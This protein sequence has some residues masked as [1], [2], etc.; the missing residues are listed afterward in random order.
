MADHPR[1]FISYSWTTP[2]HEK[3]V[4]GL[5]EELVSQGVDVIF[6]KWHL[7]PGHDANVF[8]ESMVTDPSVN[9]VILVCD[10]KY[11]QKSDERTG[12]AGTEAQIITPQL[13]AKS[14]QDKFVAVVREKH[15]N[16]AP[17][18]PVYYR[19][20]IFFDLSDDAKYAQEFEGLVR[21]AWDKPAY[22]KPELGKK[23]AFL[24]DDA[25]A[26]KIP[27]SVPFRRA[28]DAIR[29]GREYA[30][31]A[32]LEYFNVIVLEMD[33]FR[34]ETGSQN[35]DLFDEKILKNISEFIPYR[36]EFVEIIISIAMYRPTTQYG[37]I[38]HRLFEQLEPYLRRPESISSWRNSDFDNFK[39]IV[40]ELFLYVIAI[41]IKYEKF[42]LAAL[43]INTE[44]F[45]MEDPNKPMRP[46][47]IFRHYLPSFELRSRRLNRL[48]SHAD[49]LKDRCQAVGVEFRHL[50]AADFVLF[51][52]AA[53]SEFGFGW[54]PETLL[55]ARRSS[56]TIEIFA[57]AKSTAYFS[58]IA[59]MLGVTTKG[60]LQARLDGLDPRR[61][62]HWQFDSLNPSLLARAD[63]L[64]TVP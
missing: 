33:R 41:F 51:L 62:P 10:A 53:G 49:I 23:P 15:D 35:D 16:G 50:M 27:T 37:M 11:A 47:T 29:S 25:S 32:L 39:F 44:Y 17:C 30:E 28:Y 55:F 8:M 54:W 57:R 24:A 60:E 45:T 43:M 61:I 21:W 2:T 6:D 7:K 34:I 56:T 26:I 42:E 13:Y 63:E 48:S 19:G 22:V 64:A 14:E 52:R 9:K 3:W 46:F 40:H 58:R 12:G 18:L 5:A 59:P 31:A 38:L 4:V 20:R 1:L 36:N